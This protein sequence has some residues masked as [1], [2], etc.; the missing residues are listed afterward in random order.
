M[1]ARPP[2]LALLLAD[3]LS[4][5]PTLA[6]GLPPAAANGAPPP[7]KIPRDVGEFVLDAHDADPNDLPRQRWGVIAP[8]GAAGDAVLEALAPL[9]RLREAEQG[10]PAKIY[11]NAP[12]EGSFQAAADWKRKVWLKEKASERPRYLLLLGD[13]DQYSFELQHALA[14]GAFIGR[15]HADTPAGYASYADKVVRWARSPSDAAQADALFFAADDDTE[16]TAQGRVY[17]VEPC[18]DLA[19]AG[20]GF[21]VGEVQDLPPVDGA[22]AFLSTGA[23]AA[24]AVM[25][26]VSHG[27][28]SPSEGWKDAAE[29]RALQGSLLVTAP[30]PHVTVAEALVTAEKMATASFLPGG[31]WFCLACF[32][33]GTPERSAFYAWLT[34]LRRLREYRDSVDRVLK[35]LPAAGERPFL[36]AMPAAALA[37]PKGPLAVVGHVDLAWTYAFADPTNPGESRAA[38]I[39]S[40]LQAVARGSRAGVALDALMRSYREVTDELVADY[41]AEKDAEVWSRPRRV[42]PARRAHAFM[43]RNDLRGY[44]LLG[45]PAARLPIKGSAAMDKVAAAAPEKIAEVGGRSAGAPPRDPVQMERAVLAM[46]R[47]EETPRAIAARFAVTREEL[48]TWL[49]TYRAAGKAAL[50]LLR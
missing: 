25:L 17:L 15:L 32:S 41:D 14:N 40:S 20:E 33:A 36:A 18:L 2:T 21:P 44:V 28:G 12:T 4:L 16:A 8:P 23:R 35:S 50:G 24:P 1:D 38:T 43:L 7:E 34:N 45:D 3:R 26:S 11:R 31:F 46:L 29:Q 27:I 39:F 5:H 10:A 49:E 19:R 30:R 47:G 9:I 42:D 48:N 37:N 13:A 22:D 6:E